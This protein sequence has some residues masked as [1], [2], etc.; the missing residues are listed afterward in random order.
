LGGEGRVAL[1]A[2]KTNKANK[3]SSF[4]AL[5][6]IWSWQVLSLVPGFAVPM[7]GVTQSRAQVGVMIRAGWG[8]ANG[9][10]LGVEKNVAAA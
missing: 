9:R 5:E 2:T 1:R 10:V 4:F 3:K 6:G 7:P 8:L